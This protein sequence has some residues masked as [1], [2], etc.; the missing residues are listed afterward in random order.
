M[1]QNRHIT[2][3]LQVKYVIFQAGRQNMMGRLEQQIAG[4]IDGKG[5]AG[6]ELRDQVRRH[7][8]I[9][10][11]H[12]PERNLG[13]RQRHTQARDGGAD[14]SAGIVVERRAKCAAYRQ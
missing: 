9:G 4:A 10:A 1:G 8:D 12:Q 13:F 2:G 11:G 3:G 7:M 5:V 14:H 6:A